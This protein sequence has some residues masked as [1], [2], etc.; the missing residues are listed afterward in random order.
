LSSIQNVNADFGH[1]DLKSG[2]RVV[3]LSLKYNF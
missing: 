1:A 3:E 2:R